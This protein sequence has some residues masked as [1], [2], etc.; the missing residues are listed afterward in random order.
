MKRATFFPFI[1]V[2]GSL[3]ALFAFTTRQAT[4]SSAAPNADAQAYMPLVWR[5]ST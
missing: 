3:L 5:F 4:P 2:I 1:V